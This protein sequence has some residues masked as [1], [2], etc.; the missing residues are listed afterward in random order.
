LKEKEVEV[1]PK[2]QEP[3]QQQELLVS[4][5]RGSASL[6]Q[7]HS[8]QQ[9]ELSANTARGSPPPEKQS[10]EPPPPP[11][12]K[13]P[14]I[15]PPPLE[16]QPKSPPPPPKK[17]PKGPPPQENPSKVPPPPEK[18]RTP[19]WFILNKDVISAMWSSLEPFK[20]DV[21]VHEPSKDNTEVVGNF[22]WGLQK[23]KHN[24]SLVDLS[25]PCMTMQEFWQHDNR[26]YKL[27]EYEK[28]LVP[29]QVHAKLI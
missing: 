9:Q 16:N 20:Q 24:E 3:P 12:E 15:P 10:K 29:K 6:T 2:Q 11:P 28:P 5:V 8:P 7:H 4:T 14:K 13:Q 17:Q 19:A 18:Q 23:F 1:P 27:F 25:T 26:D 22:F 21:D